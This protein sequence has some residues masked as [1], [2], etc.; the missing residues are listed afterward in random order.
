MRLSQDE[1][2]LLFC[3]SDIRCNSCTLPLKQHLLVL[4]SKSH[5]HLPSELQTSSAH[6]GIMDNA[7]NKRALPISSADMKGKSAA[8]ASSTTQS[9]AVS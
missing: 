7:R 9:D 4:V 6:G 1:W 5:F 2:H 3:T 8:G